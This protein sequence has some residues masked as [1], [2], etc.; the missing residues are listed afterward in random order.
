[1]PPGWDPFKDFKGLNFQAMDD[2]DPRAAQMLKQMREAWDN[3][4]VNTALVGQ[5]VRG[6][7]TWMTGGASDT[8]FRDGQNLANQAQDQLARLQH[9]REQP[10]EELVGRDLPLVGDDGR[11]EGQQVRLPGN[12]VDQLDYVSD[13]GGRLRKLADLCCCSPGLA[14]G[15]SGHTC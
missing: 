2:G 8:F 11:V 14:H 13:F 5:T 3:A 4:P 6:S 7:W 15:C 10:V 12:G 1:M 9:R